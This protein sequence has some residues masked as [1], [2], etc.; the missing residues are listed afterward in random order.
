MLK[1][2]EDYMIGFDMD[3]KDMPVMMVVEREGSRLNV[4]NYIIG[5]EAIDLYEKITKKSLERGN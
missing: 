4:V 1:I 2:S 3:G 5:D